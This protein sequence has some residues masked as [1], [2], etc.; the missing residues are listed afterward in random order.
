MAY[1]TIRVRRLTWV[2]DG[3]LF[4]RVCYACI[5]RMYVSDVGFDMFAGLECFGSGLGPARSV[6][7]KALDCAYTFSRYTVT[8]VCAIGNDYL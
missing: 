7:F 1:A 5:R 6:C 3:V 4:T 8:E 2:S